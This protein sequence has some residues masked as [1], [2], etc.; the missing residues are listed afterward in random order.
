MYFIIFIIKITFYKF[1][2]WDPNIVY[3]NFDERFLAY[4]ILN[5]VNATS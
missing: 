2:D 4:E 1:K 5:L 3:S